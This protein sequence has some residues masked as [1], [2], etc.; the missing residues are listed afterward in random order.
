M[1]PCPPPSLCHNKKKSF[2]FFFFAILAVKV[3]MVLGK[4]HHN[5]LS[6]LGPLSKGGLTACLV[7][8]GLGKQVIVPF[9]SRKSQ[10]FGFQFGPWD[11]GFRER[12]GYV[13]GGMS[14]SYGP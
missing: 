6:S 3:S 9:V 14:E 1:C 4:L 12:R 7:K 2:F 8:V 13:S 5:Y 10:S 11:L